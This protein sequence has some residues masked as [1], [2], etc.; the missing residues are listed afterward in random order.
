MGFESIDQPGQSSEVEHNAQM[1]ILFFFAG[2]G[3]RI[4]SESID[5]PN[6]SS[7]VERNP[8]M[9]ILFFWLGSRPS[10][11]LANHQ[12][13]SIIHKQAFI[14]LAGEGWWTEIKSIDQPG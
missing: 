1:S 12:K 3:L 8:N 10:T 4:G 13:L 5:Q 11:S 7:E 14:F 9:G 6:R 2:E